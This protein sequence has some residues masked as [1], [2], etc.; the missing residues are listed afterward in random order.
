MIGA[1][2]ISATKFMS[3]WVELSQAE[4]D[5]FAKMASEIP[6]HSPTFFNLKSDRNDCP[7]QFADMSREDVVNAATEAAK[8][9]TDF[10]LWK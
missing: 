5:L 9:I 10:E 8:R 7:S 4:K 6:P 2:P 3:D 1:T